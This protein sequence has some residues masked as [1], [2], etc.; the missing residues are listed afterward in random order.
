MR[1]YN[2]TQQGKWMK[3]EIIRHSH[4]DNQM[5]VFDLTIMGQIIGIKKTELRVFSLNFIILFS[6][7]NGM[8]KGA[9]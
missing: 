7:R 1:I 3:K 2:K 9:F 4:L 8:F 6:R 5:C